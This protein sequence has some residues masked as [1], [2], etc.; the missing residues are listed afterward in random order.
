MEYTKLGRIRPVHR[1]TWNGESTYEVLEIVRDVDGR[2]VYMA[3]KAVPAGIAL[4]N[5]DYW[6]LLLDVRSVYGIAESAL[7]ASA[8]KASALIALDSGNPLEFWADVGSTAEFVLEFGPTQAG[9]PSPSNICP[10]SERTEIAVGLNGNSVSI[11]FGR[12]VGG[13]V[14]D[15]AGILVEN[16]IIRTLDGTE[17]WNKASSA[18]N[19]YYLDYY[20]SGGIAGSPSLL[21][22][23]CSHYKTSTST[24]LASSDTTFYPLSYTGSIL[25]HAFT[26]SR[27]ATLAEW[28]EYLAAQKAAGTPVQISEPL[29]NPS[30]HVCPKVAFPVLAGKNVASGL[31]NSLSVR[32]SKNLAKAYEELK[33]AILA[34]GGNV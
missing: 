26:D 28:K 20:N 17:S 7:S 5:A 23:I 31:V 12:S 24:A 19:T 34:L 32:Y 15:S 21:K 9:T 29:V 18:A 2:A 14:V 3:R 11:P 8:G 22:L 27:F 1:G 25:R 6:D 4:T 10:L 30:E 13:G 16:Q 33:N